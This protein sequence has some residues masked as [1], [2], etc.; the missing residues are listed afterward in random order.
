MRFY[1]TCFKEALHVKPFYKTVEQNGSSSI[2]GAE[3][4]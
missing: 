4:I 3:P 1:E 2:N